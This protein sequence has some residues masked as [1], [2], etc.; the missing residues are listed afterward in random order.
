VKSQ[1][2][3]P[4]G[5]KVWLNSDSKLSYPV[6]FAR[7]ERNVKL[8]GEAFF[9]VAKDKKHPFF[10]DLGEIGIEVTGTTFNAI[11]YR[12]EEQTE[13]VLTS[14]EVKIIEQND[15]KKLLITEMRP[16][17]MAV[18]K[19][20]NQR[21]SLQDVD[22]EKYTSWIEGRMI[23]RDDVM[24]EVVKKLGRRYHVEIKIADPEIAGYVYTASFK[25]ETIGQI[26]ELLKKTSPIEY[27][28]LPMRRLGDGS[29]E[30][31]KI[32]LMKR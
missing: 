30:K 12:E 25:D 17:Q 22:A 13:V 26:M 31:Q 18:Y 29:F 5:T 20:D 24:Q 6:S 3:L 28:M 7:D 8:E 9:D 14:G 23:F 32:I 21:L 4:D 11:N 27:S 1:T 2:L 15:N 19:K 10:V 16:G